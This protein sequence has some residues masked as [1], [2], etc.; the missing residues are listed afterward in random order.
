MNEREDEKN[1]RS[2]KNEKDG[3]GLGE[4]KRKGMKKNKVNRRVDEKKKQAE[5]RNVIK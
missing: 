5:E 2:K 4:I 3:R 1:K